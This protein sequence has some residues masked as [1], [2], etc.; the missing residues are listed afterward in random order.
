GVDAELV[1]RTV[2]GA[3]HVHTTTSDGSGDRAAVAAA[4]ARAGLQFVIFTDHGDGS[5]PNPPPEYVQGVLCLDGVEVSTNGGHYVAIDMPA[6]P[7]PLG[8]DAAAV[9]EDV[10]RLGGFGIAAH[11]HHP[12]PELAWSDWSAPIQ[13][14][15]WINLDSEWRD[16]GTLR[17]VR[18]P[19]DYLV[20]PAAAIASLLD[21]PVA[22]LRQWDALERSGSIT[23]LAAAD[24]HGAGRR[25]GEG[26]AAKLGVGPSYESS[27][28][29]LSNT[30]LVERPLDGTAS[31]DARL[32]F[33]AIR[34]GSVYS[35]IDA[36]ATGVFLRR[37]LDD[38]VFELASPLP[39][40]GRLD[41]VENDGRSRLEIRLGR[42]PGS[43][44]VPWVVSNWSGPR[45][46]PQPPSPP[47]LVEAVPVPLSSQWRV[48]KDPGSSAQ[49]SAKDGSMS[50]NYVLAD[51]RSSQFV[52]AAADLA[53]G[54]APFTRLLFEASADRPMRV[55]VQ[56]R[57]ADG[58]RWVKSVYLDRVERQAAIRVQD[59]T[60]ADRS[61]AVMPAASTAVSVL[62]VVDLVNARPADSGSFTIRELSRR[63]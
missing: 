52:A 13:G 28:R 1:R 59:M 4:A 20:R 33:D 25:N 22:T 7:Y 57:F 46:L 16:E 50:F 26:R 51:G 36:I 17:L 61:G 38:G 6:A 32:V 42:A 21:R 44:P 31:S 53:A 56:L 3:Y 14:I 41:P 8:G 54:H 35:T 2:R 10:A 27:F 11:P 34:Q 9:V 23:A 12:R 45:R 63:R 62:F 48:E 30:V 55:S 29:T 60:S 47:D 37:R 19:L 5:R 49:V 39:N 15:E 24:A 43:P 58:A 40:G 18:L